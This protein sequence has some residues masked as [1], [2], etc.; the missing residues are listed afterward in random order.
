MR[1]TI[2]LMLL[3]FGTAPAFADHSDDHYDLE[4]RHIASDPAS[5]HFTS[6]GE[7]VRCFLAEIEASAHPLKTKFQKPYSFC[8]TESDVHTAYDLAIKTIV[9]SQQA[10]ADFRELS[11]LI[12]DLEYSHAKLY[13]YA[14]SFQAGFGDRTVAEKATRYLAHLE[15]WYS[16][17]ITLR[18][19]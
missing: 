16:R 13:A 14:L 1:H 18:K 5:K 9:A 11:E 7:E 2:S 19:S 12:Y 8:P 10:E 6:G 3:V 17:L 4:V 15:Y